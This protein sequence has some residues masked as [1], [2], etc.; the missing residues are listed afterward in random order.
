MLFVSG[1]FYVVI[2]EMSG[3]RYDFVFKNSFFFINRFFGNIVIGVC[4]SFWIIDVFVRF[5]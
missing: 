5:Y 4:L 1:N 3:V 2:W